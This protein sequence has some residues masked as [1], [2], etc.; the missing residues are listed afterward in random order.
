MRHVGY[1]LVTLG[2]LAGAYLAVRQEEGVAPL[3]FLLALAIGAVGVALV[4][5][6][7]HR[8]SHHEERLS[9]NLEVLDTSLGRLAEKA[10]AL[11]AEKESIDVYDLRHRIDEEFPE[12]LAAF[13]GARESLGHRFGL[14]A[15]ADV[16][17][18]FS[19][20]ERYI[21]RV[22]SSSTDGYIDEAHTYIGKAREQFEEALAELRQLESREAG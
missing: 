9:S 8:E 19:A 12:D 20:G 18:P 3:S 13:V 16:M 10:R 6:A 2:F 5:V 1:L 22:W 21:N 17:N 11:D 7:L 15:Y 14:Q 4:H